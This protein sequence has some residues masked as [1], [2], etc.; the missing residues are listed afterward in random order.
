MEQSPFGGEGQ[1]MR[2]ASKNFH[3]WGL[4]WLAMQALAPRRRR[5]LPPHPSDMPANPPHLR[6]GRRLAATVST[7]PDWIVKRT[8]YEQ[9][10]WR[11]PPYLVYL[12]HDHGEIVVAIRGLNPRQRQRLP[13]FAEQ[14]YG[15]ADV[16]RP[17]PPLGGH[18]ALGPRE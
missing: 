7:P 16:R 17:R 11:C 10:E 2:T 18:L 14:P 15:H 3:W 8:T 1:I 13:H 6:G 9:T 12:D 5:R 4:P